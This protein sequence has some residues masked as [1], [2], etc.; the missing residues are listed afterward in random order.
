M[1][2]AALNMAKAMLGYDPPGAK[3]SPRWPKARAKHLAHY[4]LCAACG[5]R[6]NLT[7]HHVRPFADSPELELEPSNLLSLCE[8]GSMSC[9]LWIGHL[10]KWTTWNPHARADA[11]AFRVMLAGKKDKRLEDEPWPLTGAG[12]ISP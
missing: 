12:Q 10:G 3:R 1:F 9:H 6:V 4:P 5:G 2:A 11:S 7:V 8:K